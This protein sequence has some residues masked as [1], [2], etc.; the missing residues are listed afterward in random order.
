MMY[1]IGPITDPCGTPIVLRADENNWLLCSIHIYDLL[2][3][4]LYYTLGL[5]I[6]PPLYTTCNFYRSQNVSDNIC[7]RNM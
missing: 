5:Y 3:N 6:L 2:D 7:P 4:F 1:K